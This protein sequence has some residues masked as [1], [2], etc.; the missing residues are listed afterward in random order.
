MTIADFNQFCITHGDQLIVFG[1]VVVLGAIYW[2]WDR[3][4]RTKEF[5]IEVHCEECNSIIKDLKQDKKGIH[6][7]CPKCKHKKNYSL[8]EF[9]TKYSLS[10]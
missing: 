2:A 8:D 3:D 6:Y 5:D 7:T 1:F 10:L 4:R 9:K